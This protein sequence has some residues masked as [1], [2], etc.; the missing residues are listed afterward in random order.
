[1]DL[2]EAVRGRRSGLYVHFDSRMSVEDSNLRR[3]SFRA[4]AGG[5]SNPSLR[6]VF[7]TGQIEDNR[8]PET[9]KPCF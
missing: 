9:C 2:S 6:A 8:L 7:P 5:E 4:L 3:A 1:M